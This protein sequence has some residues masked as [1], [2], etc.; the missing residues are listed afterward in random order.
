VLIRWASINNPDGNVVYKQQA[1]STKPAA[2][3]NT[4]PAYVFIS[5]VD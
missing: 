5:S 1:P 4:R 3:E 2:Q